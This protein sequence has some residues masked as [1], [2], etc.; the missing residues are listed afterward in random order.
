MTILT[1][2]DDAFA[3]T[4]RVCG[5]L[6]T[7]NFTMYSCMLLSHLLLGLSSSL[8]LSYPCK[9]TWIALGVHASSSLQQICRSIQK[10]TIL[11]NLDSIHV[12]VP[13]LRVS[14]RYCIVMSPAGHNGLVVT[15]LT[16]VHEI[17]GSNP[18]VNSLYVCHKNI[19]DM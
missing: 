18:T 4:L 9:T 8:S 3:S 15:C 10:S 5:M 17:L 12:S 16:V 2:F 14:V 11:D 19:C 7:F 6:V 1:T 13:I